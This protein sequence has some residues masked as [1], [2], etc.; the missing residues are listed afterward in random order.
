MD[1][2]EKFILNTGSKI[3]NASAQPYHAQDLIMKTNNVD[4]NIIEDNLSR[5]KDLRNDPSF[6]WDC[7]TCGEREN[8]YPGSFIMHSFD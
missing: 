6:R 5:V 3:I 2:V 4:N 8:G 1:Q 7:H